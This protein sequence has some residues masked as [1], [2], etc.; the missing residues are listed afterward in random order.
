M[1]AESGLE[2]TH[3]IILSFAAVLRRNTMTDFLFLRGGKD[4]RSRRARL[5]LPE[6][7]NW[8]R[9]PERTLLLRLEPALMGDMALFAVSRSLL[10]CP[11]LNAHMLDGNSIRLFRFVNLGVAVD[12][13]RG[14]M[15]PT[16]FHA[17]EKRLL[18][19]SQE[20]KS[21]AAEARSGAINSD[22]LTGGT[23]T[24][25]NLGAFGVEEFTPVI[26]IRL[27]PGF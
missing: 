17:E 27:R 6:Q 7:K 9:N 4:F 3:F 1:K 19:I 5:C 13:P 16:I 14:L 26:N 23:F 8:L 10:S 20:L 15:A 21:L 18:E 24:V 22:K 12:T 2:R 25:S 11:D